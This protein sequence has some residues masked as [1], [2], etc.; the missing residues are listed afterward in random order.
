MMCFLSIAFALLSFESYGQILRGYGEEGISEPFWGAEP[1]GVEEYLEDYG[2]ALYPEDVGSDK[3][4]YFVTPNHY[5]Y[6]GWQG[7]FYWGDIIVP[8]QFNTCGGIGSI[9]GIKGFYR[10]GATSLRLP[11]TIHTI[12]NTIEECKLLEEV[13]LNDNLK[14]LNGIRNCPQ[15]RVCPLPSALE[16]VGD[17]W[18]SGTALSEIVFPSGLKKIGKHS[19]CDNLYLEH[20]NLGNVEE[21][22]EYSLMTLPKLKEIRI[23][24]SVSSFGKGSVSYCFRLERVYLPSRELDFSQSFIVCPN[25]KEFVIAATEPNHRYPAIFDDWFINHMYTAYVPD[26]SV[27]AYRQAPGW[28]EITILPMSELDKDGVAETRQAPQWNVR[29]AKCTLIVDNNSDR[30]VDVHNLAGVRLKTVGRHSNAEISV[31]PGIYTVSCDD[32][33]LKVI[34]E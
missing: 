15:L 13:Y 16:E 14:V 29:T 10:N 21:I 32:E 19:F 20:I 31:A 22:G 24:E 18:M 6:D 28:K 23:P 3:Y 26:E 25:L 5:L 11:E 7:G 9:V 1:E 2:L 33:S 4:D 27:E 34:V 30:Q 8:G 17:G 12:D